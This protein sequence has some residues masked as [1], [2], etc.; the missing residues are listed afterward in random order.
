MLDQV[1]TCQNRSSRRV[2]IVDDA[3]EVR[4]EL[5]LL[6]ELTGAFQVVGEAS[7]GLEAVLQATAQHPDLVLMDLGMPVLDGYAATRQ[8]KSANPDCRVV[9]LT[10]HDGETERQE[11][12]RAGADGFVVKGAGLETLI[13]TMSGR[14]EE[15]KDH[16][17]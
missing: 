14:E 5:A 3:P 17:E 8:I 6:L 10:V 9:V 7:N 12:A 2:L 13:Q 11:A 15:T 1:S 16:C 4:Q